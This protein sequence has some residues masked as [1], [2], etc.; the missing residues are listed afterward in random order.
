MKKNISTGLI[1]IGIIILF[2]M[3]NQK[4]TNMIK[5]NDFSKYPSPK[6]LIVQNEMQKLLYPP[7]PESYP[8]DWCCDAIC[9]YQC[10]GPQ[11]F[12][13]AFCC[14]RSFMDS[15]FALEC[16][17]PCNVYYYYIPVDDVNIN[18]RKCGVEQ[19]VIYDCTG[20]ILSPSTSITPSPFYTEPQLISTAVNLLCYDAFGINGACDCHVATQ[21]C[22]GC[23][24]KINEETQTYP[25]CTADCSFKNTPCRTYTNTASQ[26]VAGQVDCPTSVCTDFVNIAATTPCTG[27]QCDGAGNCVVIA[28]DC[29]G[30]TGLRWQAGQAISA[31]AA[32]PQPATI[33]RTVAATAISTWAAK[34]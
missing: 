20:I 2:T 23:R 11:S 15:S 9:N 26:C 25:T 34:C 5:V 27:G 10:I 32:A 3:F 7:T 33:L 1:I 29:E 4:E 17:T 13:K 19:G 18:L 8:T 16:G 21:C 31:W 28:P 24:Y 30:P 6:E 22:D 12:C 14:D